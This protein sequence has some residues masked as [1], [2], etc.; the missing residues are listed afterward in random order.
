MKRLTMSEIRARNLAAGHHTFDRKTMKFF[1]ETM[2]NW[3]AGPVAFGC[4]FVFRRGGKAGNATF[5][6]NPING[7]LKKEK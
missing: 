7:S 3:R 1:G 4:Q 6:F 5:I 2:R